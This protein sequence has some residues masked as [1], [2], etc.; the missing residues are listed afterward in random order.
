M[1]DFN[2]LGLHLGNLSWL[3]DAEFA[4]I[5]SIPV[6]VK[7]RQRPQLSGDDLNRGLLRRRLLKPFTACSTLFPSKTHGWN[8][9]YLALGGERRRISR[10]GVTPKGSAKRCTSVGLRS[11][12]PRPAV[13][14]S[15]KANPFISFSSFA[16]EIASSMF[17]WQEAVSP[18]Y[19]SD[20]AP[21]QRQLM[22]ANRQFHPGEKRL[23]AHVETLPNAPESI[24]EDVRTICAAAGS[25][26]QCVADH[27]VAC[28]CAPSS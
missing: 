3:S 20:M 26:E 5:S 24:C 9:N 19:H 16:I 2:G 1:T 13:Q 27:L 15:A 12:W 28:P 17:A 18:R 11:A 21:W 7:S 4:Q 23:L 6:C 25:L 22:T 14:A 8:W 10:A